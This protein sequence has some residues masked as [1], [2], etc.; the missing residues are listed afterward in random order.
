[1]PLTTPI[2]A[3]PG[4]FPLEERLV[5]ESASLGFEPPDAGA[6]GPG[7]VMCAEFAR[8]LGRLEE[9]APNA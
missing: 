2:A 8:R 3:D 1:M 4:G 7:A 5:R 9:T 6:H